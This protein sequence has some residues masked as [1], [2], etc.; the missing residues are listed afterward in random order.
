MANP[1]CS[2][3]SSIK[4]DR[5]TF[6]A[7]IFGATT[8]DKLNKILNDAREIA[9]STEYAD[10]MARW[11]WWDNFWKKCF[12]TFSTSRCWW[13]TP[14]VPGLGKL[15]LAYTA[16][17]LTEKW[18][19]ASSIWPKVILAEAA[20]QTLNVRGRAGPVRRIGAGRCDRH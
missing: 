14:F 2:S 20:E 15:M 4:T 16:Y 6:F 17:Q 13:R 19:R 5:E 3:A 1:D 10:R 18:S 9:I 12:R 7:K 8:N 11:A